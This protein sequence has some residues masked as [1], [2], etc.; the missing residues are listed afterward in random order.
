MN[1]TNQ[2]ISVECGCEPPIG[3]VKSAKENKAYKVHT[4]DLPWEEARDQCHSEGANLTVAYTPQKI[5]HIKKIVRNESRR[6]RE[7][8]IW[9]GIHR[10]TGLE[11]DDWVR[12]DNGKFSPNPVSL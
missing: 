10:P 2:L 4:E 8:H 9:I 12:V 11:G 3:Y 7:E 5:K 1:I 6:G